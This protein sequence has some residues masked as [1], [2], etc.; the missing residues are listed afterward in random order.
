MHAI[1]HFVNLFIKSNRNI[2]LDQLDEHNRADVAKYGQM[3]TVILRV[4]SSSESVNVDEY[5][6]Y[7]LTLYNHV[8]TAFLDSSGS[9]WVSISPTLHKLLAHSWELISLNDGE[10][11]QRLDESGL[12]GCNKILRAVRTRQARKTLQEACNADCL[13]RM[14][15]GSDPVLQAQ[16]MAALLF[17]KHCV[18]YRHG[19][20]YCKIRNPQQGPEGK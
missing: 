8:L 20:R 17:F 7:C 11:L 19:T 12:E 15:V 3:L 5:K 14:W 18:V 9:S 16:R 4:F 10:G 2:I 1:I 13:G 6:A